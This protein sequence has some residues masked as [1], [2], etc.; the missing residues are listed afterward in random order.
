MKKTHVNYLF[1]AIISFLF[2]IPNA[3]ADDT[4]FTFCRTETLQVFKI[5]GIVIT[6]IKIVIPLILI[7][8]GTIDYGKA[9]IASDEKAIKT[10]TNMLM[11]RAIAGVVIFFIPALIKALFGLVYNVNDL[12][13]D[14]DFK[15]CTECLLDINKC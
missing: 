3:F 7:I 12:G 10:A 1:I 6:I 2:L 15:K 13:N 14:S 11:K 9:I 4:V 8:F 5:L